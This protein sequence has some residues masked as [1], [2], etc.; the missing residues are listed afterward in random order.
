MIGP[1][2]SSGESFF[3]FSLSQLWERHRF[4]RVESHKFHSKI[5]KHDFIQ[6]LERPPQSHKVLCFCAE[7]DKTRWDDYGHSQTQIRWEYIPHNFT[8]QS[9]PISHRNDVERRKKDD[10]VPYFIM[11][12]LTKPL[13]FLFSTSI[14]WLN[15]YIPKPFQNYNMG[16]K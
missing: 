2:I 15:F 16:K 3:L 12:T 6:V 1:H 13:L 11:L 14:I 9:K 8:K 7:N 4:M 5:L 10:S